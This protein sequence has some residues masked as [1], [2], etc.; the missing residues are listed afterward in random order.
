[1]RFLFP[2]ALR[3]R[4]ILQ[5]CPAR[6]GLWAEQGPGSHGPRPLLNMKLKRTISSPVSLA[7][8]TLRKFSTW[9]ANPGR[10]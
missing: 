4:N 8:Y 10:L 9:I 7:I 3:G 2:P 1:M 6:P 5:P